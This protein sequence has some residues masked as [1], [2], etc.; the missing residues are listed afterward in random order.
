LTLAIIPCQVIV[1]GGERY[2]I[3]QV[4]LE[5]LLRIPA[6][7]VNRRIERVGDADVVRLRGNLLPLIRLSDIIGVTSLYTDPATGE[8][9][10]NRRKTLLD[11]RSKKSPAIPSDDASQEKQTPAAAGQDTPNRRE[12][13]GN[14]RRYHSVGALNI[15]VVSTGTMKY[16]LVV[17]HLHDSEE[18]V[19]KPLGRD[20]KKCKGYAGA[21]IMGDGR[22]ALILDVSNLAHMAGLTTVE[23][24][25]RAAEVAAS[26][27]D[28]VHAARDKQ[29]LLIFRSAENEQFAA[30]LNLVERIEKIKREDIEHV[31][32]KQV[33]KYR[34]GSLPLFRIDECAS[35]QPLADQNNLLV[36]VFMVAG[37]EIGLLAIG[38]V[39]A[40]E[41]NLS[42]DGSTLRQPGIMG[43]TI[44]ND[45]TTLIVDIVEI[46]QILNPQWFEKPKKTK[47]EE[48][49]P[50]A[51]ILF[52]EDS[53]FFRN[54]VKGSME[55]EGFI[56]LEAEDGVIAWDLL[57]EKAQDISLVVTDIEMPNM[58]GF[59]LTSKIK[60]HPA[61]AHLPVIALTTL[62]GDEDI[63]K[64][65]QVGID[66]Y[67]IKLDRE[68]LIKSIHE[69]L[70]AA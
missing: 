62:A 34:G 20:L 15:V 32:G 14:D 17:D 64:G 16:G 40:M 37:R 12:Q 23:G 26:E 25:A 58:D 8:T 19:V 11:R 70:K 51:T 60:E 2:A 30:P 45:R 41:I 24:T 6:D 52:A 39:D 31:G 10:I 50:A 66:D 65:K 3:P 54:Q 42:L 38:P 69:F 56:V 59:T 57:Q 53:S 1:T 55:K 21:T 35:V 48:D 13:L 9:A 28:A 18:I 44:I 4:N 33:M 7:Q 22:V 46:V 36:I 63:A 5:E 47:A 29:S 67:Q 61:F 49:A 27:R 68:R 43:S